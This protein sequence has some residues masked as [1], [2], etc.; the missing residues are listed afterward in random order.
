[1]TGIE[2]KS[3][4]LRVAVLVSGGG[5]NLQALIDR[6]V[7]GDLNAEIVA[8]ASDRGD[9]YGLV[10][11]ARAGIPHNVVDYGSILKGHGIGASAEAGP[12]DLV[13]LD[14]AQKIL[15][16]ADTATRL[17]RLRRLVCAEQQ[18]IGVLD[19]HEPDLICL[20]GFMR[21]ISPYFIRHYNRDNAW[22]ILNI[23]PAL[24]PAFPGQ[25]GYEDTFS[26]G[27]RWGGI[28]VHFVDEGEDTGPVIAQAVYPVWPDDSLET[29]RRRGLSLEYEIYAQCIRWLA[30]GQVHVD[31]TSPR[32]KTIITDSNYPDILESWT[33]KAFQDRSR[34]AE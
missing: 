9:A 3:P 13:E 30:A 22:R 24:L 4:K 14:A 34:K 25:H 8:V 12:V 20:A 1:M 11:A 21:L 7:K 18:L 19:R 27:C 31:T 26:H 33:I 6:S 10:R 2:G 16:I 29:I 5:T 28:T 32:P 23:H 15:R 17:E